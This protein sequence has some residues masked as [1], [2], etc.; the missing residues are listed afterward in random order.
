ME[1][2][3]PTLDVDNLDSP[4]RLRTKRK[5]AMKKVMGPVGSLTSR[6]VSKYRRQQ[7]KLLGE[8]DED[9]S[10]YKPT[11]VFYCLDTSSEE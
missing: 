7:T 4:Q 9:P 8:S 1:T 6:I 3:R 11:Y 5:S 10:P 2:P